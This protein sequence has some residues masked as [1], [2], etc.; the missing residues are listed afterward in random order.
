MSWKFD[1]KPE[2]FELTSLDVRYAIMVMMGGDGDLGR[3]VVPDLKEMAAGV[4]EDLCALVLVD[5]PGDGTDI[6]EVS[7]GGVRLVERWDE[8]DTG[9][10]RPLAD[11]LARALVSFSSET[12]IAIG[13][14][15]HGKGVFGDFD[16]DEILLSREAR[17]GSLGAALDSGAVERSRPRPRQKRVLQ[18][19]MLPDMTSGNALTNREASSA[20]TAAFARAGRTQPVDMLFFDA[21]LNSSVEVF[22]ELRGFAKTFV[23]SALQIPGA[24]WNYLYWLR[25]TAHEKP[26]TARDWAELAVATFGAEYDPRVDSKPAQLFATSTDVDFVEAFGKLVSALRALGTKGAQLAGAAARETQTIHYG[27]NLDF[28]RLVEQIRDGSENADIQKAA[29]EV[30]RLY[31]GSAVGISMA[32]AGCEDLTGMS[33]WCPLNDDREGV[34]QYYG[35]LEF[36]RVTGWLELLQTGRSSRPRNFYEMIG[37]WGLEL[38]EARQV[39]ETV[40]E[41]DRLLLSIPE[42]C[43]EFSSELVE[44]EYLF[45]GGAGS[46]QFKSYVSLREFVRSLLA[47][48]N[49][50]E[51][52]ALR[53]CCEPGWV[54]GGECCAE[55]AIDFGRYREA[56][57]DHS[58]LPE[59]VMLYENMLACLEKVAQDG[60]LFFG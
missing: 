59:E 33:V 29:S 39:K 3:M 57:S 31:E 18:R 43:R 16:P 41:E 9:D 17:F 45:H 50:G 22:T 40:F 21:C 11:F 25:A 36:A 32:P 37:C 35:E 23:G 14:W 2:S 4:S 8:I 19:S 52:E 20:L 55:M 6:L 28:G 53:G 47:I 44:G 60:V 49:E 42:S 15:G 26:T 30:V 13:F 27:E 38:V 7:V 1:V 10:P 24:G 5:L 12:M 56:F 58:T 34:G 51:F 46:I 48:R 54:I